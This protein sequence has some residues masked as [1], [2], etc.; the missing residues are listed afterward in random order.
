M[1]KANETEE[2]QR[3][4]DIYKSNDQSNSLLLS[5]QKHSSKKTLGKGWFNLEVGKNL[6]TTKHFLSYRSTKIFI[7][8]D[9]FY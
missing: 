2:S 7:Y 4:S 3:N 1:Y 8:V 5:S 9:L 6:Y